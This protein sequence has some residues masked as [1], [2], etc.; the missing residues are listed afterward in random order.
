LPK[1]L[2]GEYKG[3][4]IRHAIRKHLHDVVGPRHHK[5]IA[6]EIGGWPDSVATILSN[7]PEFASD[8]RGWWAISRY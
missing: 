8:G 5:D 1:G 3:L 2:K 4:T 7:C 6:E